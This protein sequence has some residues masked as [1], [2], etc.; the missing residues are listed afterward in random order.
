MTWIAGK[1]TTSDDTNCRSM[2][3][4]GTKLG[5]GTRACSA[6][7]NRTIIAGRSR[8]PSCPA[9]RDGTAGAYP[10]TSHIFLFFPACRPLETRRRTGSVSI[11][12]CSRKVTTAIEFL[13]ARNETA[14]LNFNLA[15]SRVWSVSG[16]EVYQEGP[17]P[18]TGFQSSPDDCLLRR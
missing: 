17:G 4:G 13:P 11:N 3:F 9:L 7:T 12:V 1:L 14:R 6:F 18:A 10:S 8:T 5:T 15:Q 16:R 2:R